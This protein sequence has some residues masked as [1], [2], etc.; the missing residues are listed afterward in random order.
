MSG[1]ALPL[2][3]AVASAAML[4][5]CCVRPIRR[6]TA[7]HAGPAREAAVRSCCGAPGAQTA[8][9]TDV[10][11][12]IK[13][14]REEVRLLRCEADLRSDDTGHPVKGEIR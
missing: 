10:D 4:Y 11:A 5:F 14:L 6:G 3:L 7:G 1:Y 12:E 9:D 13:R 2:L 8:P